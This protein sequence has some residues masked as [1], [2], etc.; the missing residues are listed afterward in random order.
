[1]IQKD[2]VAGKI[3]NEKQAIPRH[4]IVVFLPFALFAE[5]RP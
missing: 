1:M 2:A 5:N 4:L 3:F